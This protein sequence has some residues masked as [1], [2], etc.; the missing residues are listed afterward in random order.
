MGVIVYHKS[1]V[2]T[3]FR[4]PNYEFVRQLRGNEP[5]KQ[6]RYLVLRQQEKVMEYLK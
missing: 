1:G 2:R 6:Y 5:K 3:K 4:N